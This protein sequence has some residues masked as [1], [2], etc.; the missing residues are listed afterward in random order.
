[1]V[2][3]PSKKRCLIVGQGLAD[4]RDCS[5]EHRSLRLIEIVSQK[6]LIIKRASVEEE[7]KIVNDYNAPSVAISFK[8]PGA[9]IIS[10]FDGLY[11]IVAAEKFFPVKQ[12]Y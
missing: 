7:V 12:L 8:R 5:D 2:L 3:T 11:D 4:F 6:I 10:P 1:M 9:V